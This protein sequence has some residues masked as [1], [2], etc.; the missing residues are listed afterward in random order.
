ML[1]YPHRRLNQLTGEWMLVSPDRAK[2]PWR[3]QVETPATDTRPE[4]DPACF[5]CPGNTPPGGTPNPTDGSAFVIANAFPSLVPDLP[6]ATET[7]L[8]EL[9]VA[10]PERGICRVVAFGPRHDLSL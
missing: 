8:P 5:L 2:R 1:T 9:L 6:G 7:P 4:F 10:R 3:G